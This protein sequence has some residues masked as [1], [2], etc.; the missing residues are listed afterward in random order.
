MID[1]TALKEAV[2]A[3]LRVMKHLPQQGDLSLIVL[4]GHLLIEEI[5]F[6][7]VESSVKYP[8][9][10]RSANLRYYT[11]A[12]I[13]KALSYEDRAAP[14]WDAVFVLNALRN[15]FAHNLEPRDLEDKLRQFGRALSGG[16]PEGERL[17]VADPEGQIVASIEFMCG[18]LSGMISSRMPDGGA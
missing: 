5:L 11:L 16:S 4:K 7:I 15:T 2:D 6:A 8:D 18:Y 14:I 10:I 17:A 9:A 13:A 1:K 12:S 3:K